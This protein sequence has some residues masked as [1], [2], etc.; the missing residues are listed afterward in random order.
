MKRI[1]FS[2]AEVG[3]LLGAI[4]AL[5]AHVPAKKQKEIKIYDFVQYIE[6]HAYSFDWRDRTIE[7]DNFSNKKGK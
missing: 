5:A 1:H 3:K 7:I 6:V 2:E 4:L